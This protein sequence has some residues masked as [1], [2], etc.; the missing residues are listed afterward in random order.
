MKK[1]L[2]WV[3]RFCV[4]AF[5]FL[6]LNSRKITQSVPKQ[7]VSSMI[8]RKLFETGSWAHCREVRRPRDL[9]IFCFCFNLATTSLLI[10]LNHPSETPITESPISA[11]ASHLRQTITF[12]PYHFLLCLVPTFSETP[13]LLILWFKYSLLAYLSPPHHS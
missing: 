11:P 10:Y 1:C 12:T 13:T 4:D 6:W 9:G 7:R 5:I 2:R 8:K 3:H